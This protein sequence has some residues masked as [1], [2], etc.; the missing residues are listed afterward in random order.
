MQPQLLQTSPQNTP[1]ATRPVWDPRNRNKDSTQTTKQKQNL[2]PRLTSR[3]SWTEK[4]REEER[5]EGRD[6]ENRETDKENREILN[7]N[8]GINS[9]IF[10]IMGNNQHERL[11]PIRIHPP[12]ERR[13]EYQQ[14]ITLVKDNE[15]QGNRRR[16]EGIQDNVRRGI[17][18]EYRNTN[19]KR[20]DQMVQPNIHDKESERE[21]EKDTRCENTEQIDRRL[22]LQNARLERGETNN[23]IWRLGH[24]TGPLLRISPP[25][26]SD[27]IATIPSIRIPEQLLHIQSN[28]IR[29]QTLTNILCNSNGTDNATNKNENRYQN[30]QLCR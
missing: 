29:N 30:N 12:V 7:R 5:R 21:M 13:F 16:S 26:S 25:N 4:E 3:I 2:I 19:R 18:G 22:P 27:G 15:I 14:P 20:T 9:E 23:Q 6:L 24:F 1:K 28:A 11:Y 8:G 17:E 10:R